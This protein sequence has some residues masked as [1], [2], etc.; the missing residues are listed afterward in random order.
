MLFTSPWCQRKNSITRLKRW[1]SS[2]VSPLRWLNLNK[3]FDRQIISTE[4]H[5]IKSSSQKT[6]HCVDHVPQR[7]L[8]D[9]CGWC[10]IARNRKNSELPVPLSRQLFLVSPHNWCVAKLHIWP[11]HTACMRKQATSLINY[12]SHRGSSRLHQYVMV[13]RKN[14]SYTVLKVLLTRTYENI[15]C[16][17]E[18]SHLN[19]RTHVPRVATRASCFAGFQPTSF[20]GLFRSCDTTWSCSY[21]FLPSRC[22]VGSCRA[23][24][25]SAQ[26]I[27]HT[28][29]ERPRRRHLKC[30]WQLVMGT[31]IHFAQVGTFDQN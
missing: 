19:H 24:K 26:S 31:S 3:S 27:I 28:S 11:H 23:P 1:K 18:M 13:W 10:G 9:H 5:Q 2:E 16:K 4:Y 30:R 6:S 17:R 15:Y 25:L 20:V 14:T 29:N 22:Q 21:V 7:W 8:T 12:Y